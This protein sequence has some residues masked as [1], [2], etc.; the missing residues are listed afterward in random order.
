MKQTLLLLFVLIG[1]YSFS[2]NVKIDIFNNLEH[3]SQNGNYQAFLKKDIF[4]DY[5]FTDTHKNKL[6]FNKKYILAN[7]PLID[8]EVKTKISFFKSLIRQHKQEYNLEVFHEI[9]IFGNEIVRDNRD[10]ETEISTDIFD[11]KIYTRKSKGPTSTFKKGT[12]GNIEYTLGNFT[13]TLEKGFRNEWVYE[14]STDNEFSFSKK[15]WSKLISI[16]R[17]TENIFMFLLDEFT[18]Q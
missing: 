5:E 4:D 17:T 3:K 14:D 10:N 18:Y 9:D 11:N 15:T 1:T 13:A 8:K 16:H 6:H 7:Y 2:Q 12:D